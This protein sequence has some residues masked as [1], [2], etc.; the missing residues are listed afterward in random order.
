MVGVAGPLWKRDRRRATVLLVGLTLGQ[1]LGGSIIA[2]TV[3]AVG[4]ALGSLLSLDQRLLVWGL[5]CGIVGLADLIQHT[6]QVA[7]QVSKGLMHVLPAFPLGVV[8]GVDLGL[9]VTTRKT[10]S[11]MWAAL[12]GV[13]LLAPQLAP[14]LVLGSLVAIS[15]LL[16]VRTAGPAATTVDLGHVLA[17]LRTAR[18]AV[19]FT[20]VLSGAVIAVPI[21]LGLRA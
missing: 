2:A 8:W 11:L 14:L 13:L 16:T 10:T 12:A 17:L 6:P 19:G 7:R 18:T 15:T 4:S 21:A 1:A 3:W 5:I 20:V 9:M